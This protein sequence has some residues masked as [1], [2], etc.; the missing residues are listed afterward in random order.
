[1]RL[2]KPPKEHLLSTIARQGRLWRNLYYV[3]NY[4]AAS[5][6]AEYRLSPAAV[7]YRRDTRSYW[8]P[9]LGINVGPA[10]HALLAA[11]WQARALKRAGVRF[12]NEAGEIIAHTPSF[13]VTVE[14]EDELYILR[15]VVANGVYNVVSGTPGAVALDIGMNVG[16]ASLQFAAQPWVEAV[17]AYEPV[18]AT[19]RRALRNLNRNPQLA[20]RIKPHNYGLADRK[21]NMTFDFS[22]HW[23]GAVGVQGMSREFRNRHGVKDC[24]LSPV[25]VQVRSAAEVVGELKAAFPLAEVIVKLDCEGC[26]YRIIDDLHKAGLLPQLDVFL[27]EWHQS[28][29]DELLEKLAAAGYF[30][31][32]LTPQECTGMIY[33]CRRSRK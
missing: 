28:G 8:V 29:A 14:N 17:W 18:P 26:E 5:Q 3:R 4:R 25:T 27:I 20:A 30:T 19:Y 21:T 7:A 13:A 1:L 16:Y 2:T 32:S 12:S 15:E 23:R 9:E 6:M 11:L 24:D 31:L 22:P 33:A 10:H